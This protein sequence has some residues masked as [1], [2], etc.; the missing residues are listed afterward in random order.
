MPLQDIQREVVGLD[1]IDILLQIFLKTW[2]ALVY[3]GYSNFL[4]KLQLA[5]HDLAAIWQKKWREI[6]IP[7]RGKK[8]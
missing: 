6:K 3:A 8:I 5:S 1:L 7:E 4:H 2:E